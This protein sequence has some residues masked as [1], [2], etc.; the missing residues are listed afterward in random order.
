MAKYHIHELNEMVVH[1][2]KDSPIIIGFYGLSNTGK[3]TL[4]TRLIEWF[5]QKN[6][7]IATIKQT[8]H[9][10]SIDSPGKDT[11]QY[12]Q[13]G[14]ALICFQTASETTFILK[15]QVSMKKIITLLKSFD[16]FDLLI[17]EGARD[18][19]ITKIRLDEKTP[20]RE[21]TVF[22]FDDDINKVITF[23]EQ[24]LDWRK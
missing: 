7:S 14:S 12:A 20:L 6:V 1:N 17:I 19:D 3:T 23:I 8:T 13:A 16:S 10:Y 24:Q 2:M 21:N 15:K 4:I 9:S 22:T 18:K 5:A 11:W